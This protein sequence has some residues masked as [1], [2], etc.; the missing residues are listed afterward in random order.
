MDLF[1]LA[2]LIKNGVMPITY[3]LESN[4][5]IESPI[6]VDLLKNVIIV[7][8]AIAVVLFI[9]LIRIFLVQ[10]KIKLLLL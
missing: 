9:F 10:L 2:S 6:T 4:K 3:S 8:G 7:L 1:C 5:Y